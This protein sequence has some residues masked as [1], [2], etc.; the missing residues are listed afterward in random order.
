MVNKFSISIPKSAAGA[1]DVTINTNYMSHPFAIAIVER[2]HIASQTKFPGAYVLLGP[3]SGLDRPWQ[4][5]AGTI[6][7]QTFAQRGRDH[8]YTKPFWN[9][10]LVLTY[11]G[12]GDFTSAEAEVIEAAL[13][14]ALEKLEFAIRM[15][16]RPTGNDS[17][18]REKREE[19]AEATVPQILAALRLLGYDVTPKNSA[20]P[21]AKERKR[22]PPPVAPVP[23]VPT[24]LPRKPEPEPGPKRKE[25]VKKAGLEELIEEGV[26]HAGETLRGVA[27]TTSAHREGGGSYPVEDG[28]IYSVKLLPSGEVELNG[29]S[30]T[31]GGAFYQ[32][33]G[34]PREYRRTG[35]EFWTAERDG[36]WI[37]IATLRKR[38][39]NGG[40]KG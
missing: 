1:I 32:A 18:K 14:A 23:P 11:D 5:Y 33:T 12:A 36:K 31:L 37:K 15:N 30:M 29:Q 34:T 22:Q 17:V 9:R 19:L 13:D 6:G 10:A 16:K 3:A 38:W 26:L 39:E 8:V 7:K 27:G 4:Y 21:R 40:H 20:E 28:S 25:W 2:D 24:P 35:F